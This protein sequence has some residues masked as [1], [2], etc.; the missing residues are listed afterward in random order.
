[1]PLI[2]QTQSTEWVT[3]CQSPA[4]RIVFVGRL[5]PIKGVETLIKAF[6]QARLDADWELIIVGG[7]DAGLRGGTQ[8]VG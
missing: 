1:M 4:R 2:C 8:S 6:S 5:H 7:R 3:M